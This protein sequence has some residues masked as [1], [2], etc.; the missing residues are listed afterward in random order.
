MV[1]LPIKNIA[2]KTIYTQSALANTATVTNIGKIETESEYTPYIDMFYAFLAM[3]K[4]QHLKG[5]ICAYGD[6]LS[7][8]FSSD[9]ADTSVQR[10]FFRQLSS[11][12]LQ[13]E[14]ETNGVYY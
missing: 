5:T 14:I 8:N 1:P 3:S 10:G 6:T 7:F 9:L 11:D 4:G 12:G 2:I 13:V